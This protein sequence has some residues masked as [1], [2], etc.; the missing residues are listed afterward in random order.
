MLD[1]DEPINLTFRI[2]PTD[3]LGREEVLGKLRFL[4]K[5]V[6]LHWRLGE[7]VFRGGKGELKLIE[8]P[9]NQVDDVELEKKWLR[10]TRFSFHVSNPELVK[11]IPSVDMGNISFEIDKK[12]AKD[13]ERLKSFI[14]FKQ[15]LFLFEK[16]DSY[17]KDLKE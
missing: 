14:D 15:S 16:T 5:H 11:D 17:L 10:P 1:L 4:P 2:P 9:Y 12:S 8:I 7:N 3:P 6:E 13:L